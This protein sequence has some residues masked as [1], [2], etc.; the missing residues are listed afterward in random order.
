[1]KQAIIL[2]LLSGAMIHSIAQTVPQKYIEV[3]GFAE[4]EITADYLEMSVTIKENDNIKK[5][6]DFAVR[7]KNVLDAL[8]KLGIIEADIRLENFNVYRF[9]WSN[10]SNRYSLSKS[11]VVK[12]RNMDSINEFTI[13]LFEAGANDL[14]IVRRVKTDLEKYKAEAVKEAVENARARAS[15]IATTLNVSI[16]L[17]VLVSELREAEPD[18]FSRQNLFKSYQNLSATGA[19]HR[20]MDESAPASSDS[21]IDIR[22]M[23]VSYRVVIQFEIVK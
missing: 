23:K 8:K 9:G 1:M 7:E 4:K 22:K 18:F 15:L 10:S 2:F 20:G 17:P 21:N 12:V 3:S 13:R 19:V 11:Y 5:D 14:E 16:G 6:N